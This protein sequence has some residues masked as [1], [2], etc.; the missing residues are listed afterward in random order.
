MLFLVYVVLFLG[1]FYLFG[2]AFNAESWQGLIFAA[3]ILAVSLALGL[4]VHSQRKS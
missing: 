4:V 1:G 2:A 3:G